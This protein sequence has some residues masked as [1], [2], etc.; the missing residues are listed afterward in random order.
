MAY[1]MIGVKIKE[2]VDSFLVSNK[3]KNSSSLLT[4]NSIDIRFGFS[5]KTYV[6]L[7]K[8]LYKSKSYSKTI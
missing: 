3:S 5:V 4:F 7:K 2:T 1:V 6:F 8:K